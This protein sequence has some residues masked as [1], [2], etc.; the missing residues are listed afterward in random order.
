MKKERAVHIIEQIVHQQRQKIVSHSRKVIPH[1]TQE[2]LFQP[3]DY[4]ELV[5]DPEFC[6]EEGLL[7]GLESALAALRAEP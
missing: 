7:H 5:L 6:Y 4:P 2:D 1:I 3:Q